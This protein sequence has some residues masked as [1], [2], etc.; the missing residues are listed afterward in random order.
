MRRS[1]LGELNYVTASCQPAA[2]SISTRDGAA[3]KRQRISATNTS[4]LP[5]ERRAATASLCG[6]QTVR[7]NKAES[8]SQFSSSDCAIVTR[9]GPVFLAS[10]VLAV[11][12]FLLLCFELPWGECRTIRS[13]PTQKWQSKSVHYHASSGQT[14]YL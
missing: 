7:P 11:E 2:E 12:L 5:V 9:A 1:L 4:Y 3:G 10:L 8:E 13:Y 6:G 14:L